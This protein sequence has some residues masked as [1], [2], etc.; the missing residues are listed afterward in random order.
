[1]RKLKN[2]IIKST[3]FLLALTIIISLSACVSR[4][5]PL[6]KIRPLS[7]D[8][9]D[10]ILFSDSLT[11]QRD[12]GFSKRAT[13]NISG[14][15]VG[16]EANK[17]LLY[18]RYKPIIEMIYANYLLSV[19]AVKIFAKVQCEHDMARNW[20]LLAKEKYKQA[21]DIIRS[22]RKYN[23]A[24]ENMEKCLILSMQGK[25]FKEPLAPPEY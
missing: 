19:S 22:C 6:K 7:G 25:S 1:M 14:F 3:A 4:Y 12:Q 18:Q 8:C 5:K 23:E 10:Y 2:G 21:S 24:D 15:S 13:I 9:E 17:E 11:K 20:E 16:S